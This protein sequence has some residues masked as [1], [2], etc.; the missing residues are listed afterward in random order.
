MFMAQVCLDHC[1]HIIRVPGEG[2]AD[3][4][5]EV[6]EAGR[7]FAGYALSL[8]A[9]R[10]SLLVHEFGHMYLGGVPH[11]GFDT[12]GSGAPRWRSCF[13]V[14]RR[15]L[16]A[17]V[18]AENGLA[19]DTYT[20]RTEGPL[21][22]DPDF[23]FPPA[24]IGFALAND[25]WRFGTGSSCERLVRGEERPA[26]EDQWG[27]VNG[28][29]SGC[30]GRVRLEL[31]MVGERGGGYWMDVT[32]GCQCSVSSTPL[33]GSEIDARALVYSGSCYLSFADAVGTYYVSTT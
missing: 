10:A 12:D 14:A 19:V 9:E 31:P 16:W 24:E 4:A 29:H 20:A 30:I 28:T 26:D 11:C 15:H 25:I 5:W 18:V 17:Q 3:R 33:P 32:D 21:G 7:R 23:D 1:W 8:I 2:T 22:G 13:D 27:E 6:L